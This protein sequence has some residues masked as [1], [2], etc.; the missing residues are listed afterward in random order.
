MFLQK[1]KIEK[2]GFKI[3]KKNGLNNYLDAT[4]RKM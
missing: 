4:K 3:N 2:R 1:I